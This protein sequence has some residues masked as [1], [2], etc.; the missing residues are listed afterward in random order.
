MVITILLVSRGK[1][2]KNLLENILGENYIIITADKEEKIFL[3]SEKVDI[4]IIDFV[5]LGLE[6]LKIISR[7]RSINNSLTIVGWAQKE[8]KE[9][10]KEAK[11]YGVYEYID[12]SLETEDIHHILQHALERGRYQEKFKA[13]KSLDEK[14]IKKVPGDYFSLKDI[15]R[16]KDSLKNFSRVLLASYD[17]DKLLNSFL[18]L[19]REMMRIN[20]LYILLAEKEDYI[21][22]TSFGGIK[23]IV[24]SVKLSSQSE[25]IRYLAKEGTIIDRGRMDNLLYPE[26]NREMEIFGAQI[27]IPL[28]KK[29]ELMGVL[30]LGRKVTGKA[31]TEEDL[32]F[33]YF[34]T[35][36]IGI[37]IENVFLYNKITSQKKYIETILENADTGVITIDEK[38]KI[39]TFNPRAEKI[40]ELKAS[41]IIGK[42]IRSL[43]AQIADLLYESFST[44]KT[45][46]RY[47]IKLPPGECYLG[48]N[49][50]QLRNGQNQIVGSMMMFT[51]L[52]PIKLLET[53]K[54]YTEKLEFLNEISMHLSQELRSCLVP[55][56]TFTELFPSKYSDEDYR[57]KFYSLVI[58][59]IERL[60]S[61][62][63]KLLFFTQPLRLIRAPES[64]PALI[65]ESLFALKDIDF[66]SMEMDK[67]YEQD[68]PPILID[69]NYIIKALSN[70]F[71]NSIEAIKDKGKLYIRC[72]KDKSFV[73]IE[74][75]DNGEGI[76]KDYLSRVFDPF[77]T[78]HNKGIGI[79]L[80]ITQRIIEEHQGKIKLESEEGKGTKVTIYLPQ[81]N[82]H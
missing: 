5:S 43:P 76:K 32:E 44:G 1:K 15:Y 12:D 11:L 18:L 37:A 33:L 27:A 41:M 47:E 24:E 31:L 57:T 22:K 51:D 48:V 21:V 19:L 62:V 30:L 73:K 55:I 66:S 79:G 50:S 6:S 61:L 14:E 7:I 70:I 54:K 45:Y 9:L 67:N 56:K 77:F 4:I 65:E 49:T 78:T 68:L 35:N 63:E 39:I 80:T 20:R 17:L 40:L 59:E 25:L 38:E 53:Q 28:M 13:I 10:V 3:L 36:Q 26:I 23:E 52:S 42:D 72:E 60:D 71:R 74:I 64:I 81:E 46:H 82:D 34:L 58:N 69:K 75:E 16:Y 2:R 29:G 8:K